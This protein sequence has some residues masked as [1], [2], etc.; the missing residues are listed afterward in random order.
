MATAITPRPSVSGYAPPDPGGARAWWLP[1]GGHASSVGH[2][3]LSLGAA[4]ASE[5]DPS[6]WWV[7]LAHLYRGWS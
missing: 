7:V 4:D 2:D 3:R 1:R 6:G 5:R